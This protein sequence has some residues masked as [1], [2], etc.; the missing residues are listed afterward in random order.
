MRNLPGA[1]LPTLPITGLKKVRDLEYF[2]GPLLSEYRHPHGDHYLYYWCDCND[3]VNRWML[4]RVS[5]ASILRLANLFV[6]LDYVIPN[7]CQDDYVYFVD[8]DSN[9]ATLRVTL[10]GTL[11]IPDDYRPASGAYLANPLRGENDS[12]AVLIEGG[13]SVEDLGVFPRRF[14]QVYAV[15][16]ALNVLHIGRFE[17]YPWRG[18]FSAMHFFEHAAKKIPFE[19]RPAVSTIQYASPGFMRF[20]L[21]GDTARQVTQCVEDFVAWREDLRDV[22]SDLDSHIRHHKLNDPKESS[23]IDWQQH[24]PILREAAHKLTDV[25]TVID[26]DAFVS[27]APTA[28]EAAKIAM[29]FYRRVRELSEFENEGLVRFPSLP[30]Q[31][32]D[33]I[34]D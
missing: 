5:E 14:S 30:R 25:F 4:L 1:P 23:N 34:S 8:V 12:F 21:H 20:S 26:G 32:G 24:D 2:D 15:L 33:A 16:Y 22:Y 17:Q 10:T 6:P 18:G 3:S 11:Q 9:G 28:F 31:P 7:A 13:W 29:S 19:H 27:A